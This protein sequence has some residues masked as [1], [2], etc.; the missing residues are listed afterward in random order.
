MKYRFF[1]VAFLIL[2]SFPFVA[3]TVSASGPVREVYVVKRGDTLGQIIF[4][5]RKE[6]ID[7]ENLHVWN[8][9]LGTQVKTGEAIV[10]YRPERPLPPATDEEVRA[11]ADRMVSHM[12]TTETAIVTKT[13]FGL[14]G[15]GLLVLL[16]IIARWAYQRQRAKPKFEFTSTGALKITDALRERDIVEGWAR[17]KDI[18][19]GEVR[20]AMPIGKGTKEVIAVIYSG[21]VKQVR[22]TDSGVSKT[23]PWRH[24]H[25]DPMARGRAASDQSELI[26]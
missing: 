20:Y 4:T 3:S 9:D 25:R 6:G 22:W 8:P 5:L 14:T 19:D 26:Q 12:R 7:V 16:G 24:R 18:K 1:A 15:L 10:Y 21:R 17:F 23:C 2:A 11:E 13:L